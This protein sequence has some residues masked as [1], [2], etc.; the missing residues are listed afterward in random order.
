MS[1][2]SPEPPGAL[3]V[4]EEGPVLS[5]EDH[6]VSLI[7]DALSVRATRVVIPVGRLD[8]AFFDLSSRQAGDFLQKFINYRL[9]VAIVGDIAAALESSSALRAFVIESNRGA[10]VRFA[11]DLDSLRAMSPVSR[12]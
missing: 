3:L 9:Q 5:T 12:S 8:P 10:S 7:G 1:D 11:P 2:P 6:A 4:S